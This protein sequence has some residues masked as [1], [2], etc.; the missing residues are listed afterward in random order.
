MIHGGTRNPYLVFICLLEM[1]IMW[2]VCE[3]DT[4]WSC[5][6]DCYEEK[7]WYETGGTCKHVEAVNHIGLHG[8]FECGHN[9]G[10]IN[11]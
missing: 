6:C 9:Q 11:I 4:K 2:N 8:N 10:D 1:T 5:G 3:Y 7:M